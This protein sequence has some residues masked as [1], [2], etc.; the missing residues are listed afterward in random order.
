MA[1]P[2]PYPSGVGLFPEKVRVRRIRV[3]ADFSNEFTLQ[4]QVQL[5]P[6][7]VYAIDVTLQP[8]DRADAAT[9]E[10]WLEELNGLEGTFSFDLN[11]W[12]RGSLPGTRTF[13]MVLPDDEWD[14][15]LAVTFGFA[16][17]AQ[18]VP[19]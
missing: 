6:T 10:S 16:F 4:S 17:S 18:E 1:F 9:M 7:M 8:L 19:S 5:W 13:R 2:L 15:E 12:A 11:P 3:Q 14:G